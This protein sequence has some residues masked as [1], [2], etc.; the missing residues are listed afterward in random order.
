MTEVL[1]RL[2]SATDVHK[3]TILTLATA[4]GTSNFLRPPNNPNYPVQ[5]SVETCPLL[6]VT[7]M[8]H[9]TLSSRGSDGGPAPGC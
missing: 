4:T 5:S 8:G 1:P 7:T 2:Q 9:S 3:S 6:S